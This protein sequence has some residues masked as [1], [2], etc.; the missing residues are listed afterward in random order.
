MDLFSD[1]AEIVRFGAEY[2]R[3]TGP[4]YGLYGLGM[5]LLF[6]TQGFGRVILTVT[7]NVVRL[8][9]SVGGGLAAITWFD[10]GATGFFVAVALGFC[11]YAAITAYAVISVQEGVQESVQQPRGEDAATPQLASLKSKETSHVP[12]SAMHF[13][14]R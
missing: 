6:A 3:T 5:G 12:T 11:V 2:L 1:N 7:A 9:V 8:L 4:V 14:G 10:L 13:A